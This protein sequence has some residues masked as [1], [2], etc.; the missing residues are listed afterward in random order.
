MLLVMPMLLL[1]LD[2]LLRRVQQ[3][4]NILSQLLNKLLGQLLGNKQPAIQAPT[5]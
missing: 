2:I 4:R 5:L 1:R 3:L